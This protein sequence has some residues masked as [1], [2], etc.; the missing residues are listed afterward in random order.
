MSWVLLDKSYNF[1]AMK[2]ESKPATFRYACP[3]LLKGTEELGQRQDEE[4][5][6]GIVERIRDD[7][8]GTN[9]RR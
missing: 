2:R 4:R 7:P 9:E 8:G 3:K 5:D 1:S 6:R